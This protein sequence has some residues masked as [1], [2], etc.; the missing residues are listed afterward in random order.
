MGTPRR[1]FDE[2]VA[3]LE[4][5]GG[6]EAVASIDACYGHSSALERPV[7]VFDLIVLLQ[8]FPGEYPAV[9]VARLRY[10][11]PFVPMILLLGSWCEGTGR[12]EPTSPG[13]LRVYAHQWAGRG[14]DELRAI[15]RGGLAETLLP[16]TA[17]EEEGILQ[18]GSPGSRTEAGSVHLLEYSEFGIGV[19]PVM[20]ASLRDIYAR[21][22]IATSAGRLESVVPGTVALIADVAEIPHE[23]Y[24]TC[25]RACRR[26]FSELPLT[27][28]LHAPRIEE[29]QQLR[30]FR[31]VFPL[32]KPFRLCDLPLID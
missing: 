9:A 25:L 30:E 2:A 31:S 6:V 23:H 27:L 29:L 18:W 24:A 8:S 32:A 22:A 5:F 26:R 15:L 21:N 14:R 11:H 19:D 13:L 20:V 7:P 3:D 1:E 28:L 17:S 10:C 4:R 12:T 16:P